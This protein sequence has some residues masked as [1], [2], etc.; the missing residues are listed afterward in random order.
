MLNLL[1]LK[2]RLNN[3][4]QKYQMYLIPGIKFIVAMIVFSFINSQLG[5]DTR[6][7][8]LVIVLGMSLICAFLPTSIMVVFALC[9]S[10]V[11]IYAVSPFIA[12]IALVILLVLYLLFIRFTPKLGIV[13]LVM[14]ILCHFNIP[15]VI[16]LLFGIISTPIAIIPVTCGVVVYNLFTIIR[17]MALGTNGSSIED[18]L[19]MYQN[20]VDQLLGNRV[21]ILTICAFAIV[22]VV[23]YLVRNLSIDHAFEIAIIAGV[24][25]NI[26][27]FLIGDIVFSASDKIVFMFIGSI[28]SGG[29]V[30]AVQFF[31]LNLDYSTVERVQ[32]EDDDYYYYVKAVPKIKVTTPE[33]SVKRFNTTNTVVENDEFDD[34][35]DIKIDIESV[36]DNNDYLKQ[37]KYEN[38]E[39]SE[40]DL[41]DGDDYF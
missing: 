37:K 6:L 21:M 35:S 23:T 41:E 15:Y 17:N 36:L 38:D 1:V 18:I 27:L 20:M 9:L 19:T 7:T 39:N 16:P 10:I 12:L 31:R 29:I 40:F 28:L 25:V 34:I 4:Y 26:L 32:F 8:K 5:Y 30:Y 24:I 22:I 11:H 14:P 13:V 2:E 3:I 33:K